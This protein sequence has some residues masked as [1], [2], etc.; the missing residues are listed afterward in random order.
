MLIA[1]KPE[2]AA[3]PHVSIL[4]PPEVV[5]DPANRLSL[6]LSTGGTVVIQLRPD[7]APKSVERLQTLARQGF[8]DGTPFHR[9]I[10]GFMAQGGDPTGTGQGGSPL[11]D[12][13]A[14]FNSLPHVRG[15]MAMA[16]TDEPDSANSQ[17]YLMFMPNVSL[18]HNYTVV[19][20]II[21]GMDAASKIAIGEPPPNPTRIVHAWVGNESAPIAAAPPA[22]AA[23]PEVSAPAG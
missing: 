6:Q 17:F 21:S 23:V 13:K 19:G 10:A 22:P 5:A 2:P 1:A 14:E 8:Y 20:R 12:L 3:E 7:A 16:R 18:D 9:V 11:P 4:P 15:S